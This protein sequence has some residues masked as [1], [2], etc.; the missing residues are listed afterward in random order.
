MLDCLD[1]CSAGAANCSA[2]R[3]KQLADAQALLL[4]YG[5]STQGTGIATLAYSDSVGTTC[6]TQDEGAAGREDGL[7]VGEDGSGC[8]GG[9]DHPRVVLKKQKSLRKKIMK[10]FRS[11]VSAVF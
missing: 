1:R 4:L 7:G 3:Q 2:D 8:A 6:A 10:L 11:N 5:S 9:T